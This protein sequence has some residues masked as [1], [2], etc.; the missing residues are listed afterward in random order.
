MGAPG[1]LRDHLER[2]KAVKMKVLILPTNI[3]SMPAITTDRLLK[4]GIKVRALF[5]DTNSYQQQSAALEFPLKGL[6]FGWPQKLWNFGR[7]LFHAVR[8]IFWADVIHY[9]GSFNKQLDNILFPL[10][11]LLKKSA[12]VEWVGSDIRI[13]EV[14]FVDN[15]YYKKAYYNGYEYPYESMAQS[16]ETQ[17]RFKNA[18]FHPLVFPGMEQYILKDIF[19]DYYRFIQRIDLSD[20][21]SKPPSL[22][23][24]KP[25]IV[26][27]PTA[28]VAKGTS[29]IEDALEQ[30]KAEFDFDYVRAYKMKRTDVLKEIAQCD[31]F[32]DQ[33][34]LGSYGMAAMEAFAFAK[35]VVCF[36]KPSVLECFP[37]NS[38]IINANP[39]SIK[40]VLRKL[41]SDENFRNGAGISSRKYAEKYHDIDSCIEQLISIYSSA[42]DRSKK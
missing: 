35:P 19:P 12:M 32:V 27:A 29:Y 41:L 18:G 31:I 22:D 17:M 6:R 8:G 26:H 36:M 3:A 13:P 9:C 7:F 34:I 16:R 15:P 39:D 5:L 4:K 33:I 1:F 38:P 40:D 2:K 20:Y 30:L 21:I 14:E 10:I 24:K 28:P 23:V 11:R 25:R 42:I 37:A